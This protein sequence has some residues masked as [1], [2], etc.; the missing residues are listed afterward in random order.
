MSELPVDCFLTLLDKDKDLQPGNV[1]GYL[2]MTV[3]N[4]GQD[5]DEF[6]TLQKVEQERKSDISR[7]KLRIK[8]EDATEQDMIQEG[9][10]ISKPQIKHLVLLGT[11]NSGKSTLM[12]QFRTSFGKGFTEDDLYDYEST[13]YMLIIRNLYLLTK[14]VRD[15]YMDFENGINASRAVKLGRLIQEGVNKKNVMKVYDEELHNDCLALWKD[16]SVQKAI[17]EHRMPY[18]ESMFHFFENKADKLNPNFYFVTLRDFIHLRDV[19]DHHEEECTINGSRYIV[20]DELR[21]DI[22]IESIVYCCSLT[23][24]DRI[25]VVDKKT[26]RL[27]ESIEYFKYVAKKNEG[28]KILVALTCSDLLE[29]SLQRAPFGKYMKEYRGNNDT[30]EVIAWVTKQYQDAFHD[31]TGEMSDLSIETVNLTE[32]NAARDL[33]ATALMEH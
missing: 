32:Y 9:L 13:V 31:I 16:D 23:S 5:T 25:S 17:S 1:I 2:K 24:Y 33:I 4:I 22:D 18:D 21:S 15:H 6:I 27:Q 8:C 7:V 3:N 10:N 26:N 20:Y 29:S 11:Y 19:F 30:K 12:K 28:K 14:S